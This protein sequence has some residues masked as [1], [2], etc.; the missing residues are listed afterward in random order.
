VFFVA[1]SFSTVPGTQ[2]ELLEFRRNCHDREETVTEL[3]RLEDL[4]ALIGAGF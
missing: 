1:E 4:F 3:L 2:T